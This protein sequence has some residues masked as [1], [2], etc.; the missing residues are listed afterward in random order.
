VGIESKAYKD[1]PGPGNYR[2]PS[3]FANL[4]IYEKSRARVE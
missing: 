3:T 2:V 4:P 1:V